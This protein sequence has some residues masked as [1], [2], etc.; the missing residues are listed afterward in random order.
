MTSTASGCIW[1]L[2]GDRNSAVV[3]DSSMG[4]YVYGAFTCPLLPASTVKVNGRATQPFFKAHSR[5][6]GATPTWT[7]GAMFIVSIGTT[8]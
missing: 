3:G 5:K 7:V 8:I 2:F 1:S 6:G 4:L